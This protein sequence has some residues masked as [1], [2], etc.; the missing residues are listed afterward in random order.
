[1]ALLA[2]WSDT[3]QACQT[4]TALPATPKDNWEGTGCKGEKVA[5]DTVGSKQPIVA[6]AAVAKIASRRQNTLV[7]YVFNFAYCQIVVAYDTLPCF[8]RAS[9]GVLGTA[10]VRPDVRGTEHPRADEWDWKTTEVLTVLTPGKFMR[11][12]RAVFSPAWSTHEGFHW[13]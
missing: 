1:M 13:S 11:L 5:V 4:R 12:L 3:Y 9:Q 8:M 2:H 10:S 6:V 7:M